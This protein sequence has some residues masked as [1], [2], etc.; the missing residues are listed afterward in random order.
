MKKRLSRIVRVCI[1]PLILCFLASLPASEAIANDVYTCK[2]EQV[3]YAVERATNV[4]IGCALEVKSMKK[5]DGLVLTC[6]ITNVTSK[7]LIVYQPASCLGASYSMQ[8]SSRILTNTGGRTVS[9]GGIPKETVIVPG[10]ICS[11]RAVFALP[12]NAKQADSFDFTTLLILSIGDKDNGKE[13][14]TGPL[15]IKNV[16]IRKVKPVEGTGIPEKQ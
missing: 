9:I 2:W 1:T 11:L 14:Y 4:N 3:E 12:E 15:K 8:T 7:N 6:L 10:G 5:G 16:V 13:E